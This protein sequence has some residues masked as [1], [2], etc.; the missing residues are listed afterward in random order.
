MSDYGLQDQNH[1][2]T[3]AQGMLISGV[4]G[5][6]GGVAAVVAMNPA[7]VIRTRL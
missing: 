6:I 7:D 5:G 3:F 1:G 2:G 4:T